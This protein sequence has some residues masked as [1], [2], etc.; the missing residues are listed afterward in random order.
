MTEQP[1]HS[2]GDEYR[3]IGALLGFLLKAEVDAIF[4]QQPFKTAEGED[5]LELWRRFDQHRQ[6]LSAIP[7]GRVEPLPTSLAGVEASIRQRTTYRQYYES[8]ADYVFSSVPIESLVAPQWFADVDYIDELAGKLA[9][10]LPAEEQLRFALSEGRIHQPIVTGSQVLFTSPRRDLHADQVPI[11][12]QVGDGEFEIVVRAVSR[13]NYVQ[14]AI[15][16]NRLLLTNGVHK[17]CALY[18]AGF[19][20][21]YCVAREV[22]NLSETGLNTQTSLFRDPIFT[23]PRPASV[24]DFLNS[25]TA[26]P[27]YIRSMFQILQ[28]AVTTG[29]MTVPALPREP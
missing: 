17:V 27:L 28:V 5:P 12:R 2:P 22:H 20:H 6:T 4:K 23:G 13:P 8:V 10:D 7:A 9:P 14:V 1:L 29:T 26:V 3:R 11:V 25:T 18:K 21:C 15:I 19:T 16:E 24:V